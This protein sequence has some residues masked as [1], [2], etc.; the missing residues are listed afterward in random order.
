MYLMGVIG[1]EKYLK[2]SGEVSEPK[3]KSL[4]ASGWTDLAAPGDADSPGL[5]S[6]AGVREV[7]VG[8]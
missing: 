1:K 7:T 4:Q 5:S 6:G 2:Y 3:E 8:D